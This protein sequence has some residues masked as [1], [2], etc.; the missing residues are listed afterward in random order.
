MTTE[1]QPS[2]AEAR[3]RT[4]DKLQ[5]NWQESCSLA[6][7]NR[8]EQFHLRKRE[9][10]S[11]TR[12]VPVFTLPKMTEAKG[13]CGRIGICGT[14]RTPERPVPESKPYDSRFS[15]TSQTSIHH[16]H[17][18]HHRPRWLLSGRTADIEE[19]RSARNQAA[20]EQF[21]YGTSGPFNLRLARPRGWFLPPFRRL[22]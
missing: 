14:E 20:L 4:S 2:A 18:R 7:R 13:P 15:G 22:V 12:Q 21:Q 10:I 16:R 6:S 17:H 1:E 8:P 11:A 3:R 19:L 9:C 5:R